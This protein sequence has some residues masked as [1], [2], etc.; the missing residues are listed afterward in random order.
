[1]THK[2]I[3]DLSLVKLLAYLHQLRPNDTVHIPFPQKMGRQLEVIQSPL[4]SL[5][6][7][8][9]IEDKL[10]VFI[11]STKKYLVFPA[12]VLIINYLRDFI[13]HKDITI[14]DI[15]HILHFSVFG[16]GIDKA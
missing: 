11:G 15:E 8:N 13:V 9:I 6:I 10:K 4:L 16:L 12:V 5:L 14:D 2:P 3:R 7:R 1:M